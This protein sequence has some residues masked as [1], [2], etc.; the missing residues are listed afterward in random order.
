MS[1]ALSVSRMLELL[2][3]QGI[4]VVAVR[5][6][7]IHVRGIRICNV[8]RVVLP[9]LMHWCVHS[10]VH[11]H[12][13]SVCVH[14]SIGVR[15]VVMLSLAFFIFLVNLVVLDW[16]HSIVFVGFTLIVL[17]FIRRERLTEKQR[18]EMSCLKRRLSSPWRRNHKHTFHAVPTNLATE[19]L[20]DGTPVSDCLSRRTCAEKNILSNS[21]QNRY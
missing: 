4:V 3:L 16:I 6:L 12:V 1:T 14:S 2:L 19:P 18:G 7:T 20:S 11:V 9:R 10:S 21:K 5:W 13:A 8:A 17:L 15:H